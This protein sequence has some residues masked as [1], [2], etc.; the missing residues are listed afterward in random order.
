[1]AKVH[2]QLLTR[3]RHAL[4]GRNWEGF[5]P[6][7][8][9]TG[10]A[11][12]NTIEAIQSI[13]VQACIKHYIGNEQELHRSNTQDP[14]GTDVAAI[15]SNIDDRTMH[16]LYLWPFADTIKAGV[17][18]VM[19]SY[20]RINQTYGCEN[21]KTLNGLLKGE[22]GFQGY[23]VSDW[24]ATHSSNESVLGGLDMDMP[25]YLTYGSSDANPPSYF[26]LNLTALVQNGTIPE[27]RLDDMIRRIMTP[28]YY[29]GQDQGF[30]TVD[31]T[32]QPVSD[33]FSN[34][35]QYPILPA[36]D[37][38]ANHAGLIRVIGSA[39]TVLLKNTNGTLPLRNPRN[40]A[41]FG[42]DAPDITNGL[43]ITQ[44]SSIGTLMIG[45]GSGTARATYVISPLSAL[46]FK[47]AQDGTRIQY[48]T[49]NQGI[50][51]GNLGGLY[52]L[53]EVCLV[54]LKTY[55]GEGDDR[56]MYELDGNS[57]AAM[58][59][60]LSVCNNTVV[61]THSVGI[62]TMPWAENPN[63]T[64]IL[65]ANL[66]GQESGNSIIDILYG[67]VNP[68][69]KLPYTIARNSSDYNAPIL[70]LTGTADE[71]NADAWQSDFTE[72]QM[73][74]YR[75][76]DNASIEPLFEFGFGLSYT[77]FSMGDLS[78]PNITG[79]ISPS[80]P[81]TSQVSP[82]GNPSLWEVLLTP[83]VQV[84]NTGDVPGATVPQLYISLPQDNVPSGTPI[85]VLRGFEKVFLQPNGTTQVQFPLKRRDLSYWNVVSQDWV[86]PA[87]EI[88]VSIGF[89]SRDL[90]LNGTVMVVQGNTAGN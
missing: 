19:C 28:Y 81:Q 78:I 35:Y 86:I 8:Y 18:S 23:V 69:G 66:P 79:S 87:G 72:G 43:G 30:P 64:A 2:A 24:Q 27:A 41:V 76:F 57:T 77:T 58:S 22:L 84:S 46:L 53:P 68:S 47:A 71:Y 10:V 45:G 33:A 13:G 48:V 82:G 70:N 63:V 59:Q 32:T 56:S 80:P 20:N 51:S 54:F 88:G 40:I 34:R 49:D 31:P 9:L 83:T 74:D 44:N 16:E 39:G 60:I 26:G 11:A 17:A 36:R 6:D 62:N 3:Y 55:A 50:A 37:V 38:R 29:L 89:S 25:G 15:T 90:P 7:P 52:P 1:M 5:S 73:I 67:A 12:A 85:R 14:N 61:V 75:H 42:N 4:G 65:A 21:S